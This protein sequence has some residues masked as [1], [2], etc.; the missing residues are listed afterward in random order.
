[1]I[2]INA[3]FLTQNTTGVQRY[4]IEICNRFPKEIKNKKIVFVAPKGHL[5]N[6]NKLNTYDVKQFGSFKGHLWEQIDLINFLKKNNNPILLNFGGIGPVYYKNK[7]TYVHDLAFKYY[8]ETFS[9]LFQKAYNIFVPISA[10]NALRVITVSN[11][12]KKDIETHFKI[13]NTEV[14]Y[15]AQS[16]H[17]KNLSLKREKIILAVSSLDPRKNFNRIINAYQQLDTDYKLYFVGAKS[18]SFS[19][20]N[21]N[22]ESANENIIFTGY[23]NDNDLIKLY[24]RASIFIYASLFEG[25]GMPPL[26]A[27]ACGCPCIVSN[28]TSLPEVYLDSV[29]Y[30]EPESIESI[31]DKLEF[32]IN[33]KE[34]RD[35]LVKKGHK[36]TSRFSWD[37]SA[38]KLTSIIELE[39]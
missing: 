32:L 11:Y 25:F 22:K 8:P 31:K 2:V 23:L 33:N 3:R 27:Q 14:V 34:R 13:N 17:F 39:V 4:A 21:I 38:K 36:N 30:C 9:Y 20:I 16:N 18:K 5:M 7:I 37:M 6:K 29:E 12:V 1:M 10:R 15:C 26:E 24:N 19:E 35:E 28:K